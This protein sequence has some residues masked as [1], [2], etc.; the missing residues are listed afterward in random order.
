MAQS[1]MA[2]G[3]S[4]L[5]AIITAILTI[6]LVL[7]A[8]SRGAPRERDCWM[9]LGFDAASPVV[10]KA[11]ACEQSSWPRWASV[12]NLV[13]IGSAAAEAALVYELLSAGPGEAAPFDPHEALGIDASASTAEVKA[14]YR[15]LAREYHPDKNPDPSAAPRFSAIVK[16]HAI[17]TDPVAARNFQQYGSPDGFQGFSFGLGLPAWML[18]EAA[19]LPALLLVLGVPLLALCCVRGDPKAKRAAQV[20]EAAANLYSELLGASGAKGVREQLV[21]LAASAYAATDAPGTASMGVG[22]HRALMQLRPVVVGARGDAESEGGGAEGV[23]A[24]GV[25]EPQRDA[26]GADSAPSDKAAG[27]KARKRKKGAGG[28]GHEG[29]HAKGPRSPLAQQAIAMAAMES[30]AAK[31][32]SASSAETPSR[33]PSGAAEELSMDTACEW[34]LLAYLQRRP[35]P[36]ELRELLHQLLLFAPSILEAFFSAAVL[37]RELRYAEGVRPVLSLAQ[38]LY[39]AL[40][41]RGAGTPLLQLLQLPHVDTACAARLLSSWGEGDDGHSRGAHSREGGQRGRASLTMAAVVGM[42]RRAR[43]ALLASA[44][45]EGAA[46]RGDVHAFCERAFPR[47]TLSVAFAGVKGEDGPP[48]EGDV[49]TVAATLHLGHRECGTHRGALPAA[50]CH[51]PLFPHPK[52][53]AWV[54][55]LTAAGG[56]RVRAVCAAPKS[57]QLWK[58]PKASKGAGKG[59]GGTKRGAGGLQWT[60]EMRTRATVAGELALEVHAVCLSYAGCDAVQA[61]TLTVEREGKRRIAR[62]AED[63][64]E[65]EVDEDE[66][67]EDEGVEEEDDDWVEEEEEE[68]G[69]EGLD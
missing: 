30:A 66:E 16:A 41:P 11:T 28:G 18:H 23:E 54:L 50:S 42:P 29:A 38:S 15:Q 2:A 45:L 22:Q 25:G 21:R 49:L 68:E 62:V 67:D 37:D 44:G 19:L 61:V 13:L 51:A 27:A 39:Q 5:L 65:E 8:C 58:A 52:P 17:L 9:A 43:E 4:F 40:P 63:E 34:L 35:V 3:D 7:K 32:K 33:A 64:D 59:K 56:G 24:E 36:A 6:S 55:V 69:M 57:W 53:E 10:A 46:A 47:P 20:G 31:A 26:N 1:E 14:A 60:G 12:T 48:M